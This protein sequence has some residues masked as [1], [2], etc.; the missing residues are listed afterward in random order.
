ML[1]KPL[2]FLKRFYY[3][4]S[5]Y[6]IAFLFKLF[7]AFFTVATLYFVAKLVPAV[8]M[9]EYGGSYFSFVLIGVAFSSFMALLL[10]GFSRFIRQAQQHGRF[11]LLRASVCPPGAGSR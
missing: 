10:R 2:A 3:E 4:E 1:R 5:S 7:S 6:K 11:Q 9:A 8:N